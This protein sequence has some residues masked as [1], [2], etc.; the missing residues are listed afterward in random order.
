M[1][2]SNELHREI[3]LDHVQNPRNMKKIGETDY[4]KAYLKN[5]SCGDDVL[6]YVLI[7]NNTIKDIAYDVNGCSI[8]KSS[9]SIMSELLIGKTKDEATNIINN[10][11][12]M[13]TNK[14]YD[15]N[16]IDEAIAFEGVKNLPP[17]IK[18]TLLPYKAYK[19]AVGEEDGI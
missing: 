14:K 1:N 11:N 17:R 10:I 12:N 7:D 4:L 13:L 3:I 6:I 2:Y 8:C 18:C 19:K 15:S 16:L 9:T 5:P